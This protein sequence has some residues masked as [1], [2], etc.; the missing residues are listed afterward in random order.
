MIKMLELVENLIH[1]DIAARNVLLAENYV[2]KLTGTKKI[3]MNSMSI[4]SNNKCRFRIESSI[5][6]RN[7]STSYI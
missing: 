1:R 7:E 4:H 3:I 6:R 2:A 5:G